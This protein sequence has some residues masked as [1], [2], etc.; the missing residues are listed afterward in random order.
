MPLY[1]VKLNMLLNDC[2]VQHIPFNNVKVVR[3]SMLL[4]IKDMPA[5]RERPGTQRGV[6]QETLTSVLMNVILMVGGTRANWS[7]D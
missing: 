3:I 5:Q 1:N 7:K 2:A 4:V 6:E